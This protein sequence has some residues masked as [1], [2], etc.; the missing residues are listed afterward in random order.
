[1]FLFDKTAAL[2][3]RCVNLIVFSHANFAAFSV[4]SKTTSRVNLQ[5]ACLSVCARS[6]LSIT[7]CAMCAK[8]SYFDGHLKKEVLVFL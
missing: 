2:L 8:G 4:C 6:R 1:V 5:V 7:D 3:P